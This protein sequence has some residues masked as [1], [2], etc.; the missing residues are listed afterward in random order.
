MCCGF[1]AFNLFPETLL[2]FFSP[3][4]EMVS[5]GKVALRV[6]SIHFLLAGFD[7]IAGSVCQAIGNPVHSLIVSVCRQLVALLPIAWIL[8]KTGRL[9]LVWFAFPIAELVSLTLCTIFI[10]RTF[11]AADARF[12]QMDLNPNT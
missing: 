10:R 3:S 4:A 9:D 11:R 12:A 2:G 5:I 7:I 8:S 1:A 6:I